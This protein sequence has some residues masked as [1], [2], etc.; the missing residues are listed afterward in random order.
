M[1]NA[2]VERIT[3]IEFTV[4]G[5]KGW[6]GMGVHWDMPADF[7][8]WKKMYISLKSTTPELM[9]ITIAMNSG[10]GDKAAVKASTYGYK[11]DGMWHN[12]V[13]PVADI[14]ATDAKFNVTA[15]KDVIQIL[16]S[17]MVSNG[18]VFRVD[19]VFFQ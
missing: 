6:F 10:L 17:G 13:I 15:V 9:D 14:A 1:R 5:G 16:N 4:A 3:D 12:L 8:K 2:A 18:D 7:T 19:N 11:N